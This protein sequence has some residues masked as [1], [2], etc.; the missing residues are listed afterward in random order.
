MYSIPILSKK[1]N[2]TAIKHTI[3]TYD[4]LKIFSSNNSSLGSNYLDKSDGEF[5][6]N[7]DFNLSTY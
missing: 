3:V 2:K 6:E 5:L 7:S 4:L 1:L